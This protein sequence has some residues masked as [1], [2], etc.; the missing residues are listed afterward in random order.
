METDS[1]IGLIQTTIGYAFKNPNA[2]AEALTAAGADGQNYDGN[3]RLAQLG[4]S[5]VRT[6]ILDNAYTIGL[7]RGAICFIGQDP[8]GLT[9]LSDGE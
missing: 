8:N 1:D 4:D 2:L 5:V 6:V 7:S 9:P 3:R